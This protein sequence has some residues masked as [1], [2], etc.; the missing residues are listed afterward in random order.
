MYSIFFLYDE[1]VNERDPWLSKPPQCSTRY[2]G[3]QSW[4]QLLKRLRQEDTLS[5]GVQGQSEKQSETPFQN[6][7]KPSPMAGHEK[8]AYLCRENSFTMLR[9]QASPNDFNSFILPA[10]S[11]A[12]KCRV[13]GKNTWHSSTLSYVNMQNVPYSPLFFKQCIYCVWEGWPYI[14]VHER[15]VDANGQILKDWF[16]KREIVFIVSYLRS[17]IFC[18]NL[19]TLYEGT[20]LHIWRYTLVCG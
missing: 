19:Q 12:G 20:L 18:P 14:Q 15:T 2:G 5:S 11:I 4:S 17:L 6:K 8:L 1:N 13:L 3:R 9:S 16:N 10:C 7:T